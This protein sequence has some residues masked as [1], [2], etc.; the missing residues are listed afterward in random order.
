MERTHY[1]IPPVTG[2]VVYRT[3]VLVKREGS[4][5]PTVDVERGNV[6]EFSRKSR[7]RLAFVASNTDVEFTMMITLTYPRSF[8][9]DGRTVKRHLNHFLTRMRR[10]RTDVL[11]LWF[12]EWQKRGAPH[13]H[14]LATALGELRTVQL[15]VSR[16]W[17]DVVQ[18][19]DERHLKAGTRC[20]TIRSRDG[21]R[22][23]AVK[24]ASKMK[25][26]LVPAGYH[27]VGRFW[28]CSRAVRPHPRREYTCTND[29]L[30]ESL[31]CAGW[32][33]LPMDKVPYSVLYNAAA[34]LTR[35]IESDILGLGPSPDGDGDT[36]TSERTQS[37]GRT[38]SERTVDR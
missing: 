26:K 21:A 32:D 29:D 30:V 8:P 20:E 24:Y 22:H 31:R 2:F 9:S 34:P 11:Y 35:Y 15:W 18:S 33:W 28:G 17:Y 12:L 6:T 16:T 4:I 7:Q 5:P 37:D 23:Y 19:G 10:Y 36:T 14:I 27:D 13:F 38:L 1:R 25:Q 3:D